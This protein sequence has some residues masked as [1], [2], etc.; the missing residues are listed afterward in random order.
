MYLLS[1]ASSPASLGWSPGPRVVSAERSPSN[2]ARHGA[3]VAVGYAHDPDSAEAVVEEICDVGGPSAAFALHANVQSRDEVHEAFAAAMKG[4]G[5]IDFLVNN[6][7][8]N[9]RPGNG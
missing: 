6:A 3:N 4:I 5:K 1:G 7:G 8:I 9:P 2:L